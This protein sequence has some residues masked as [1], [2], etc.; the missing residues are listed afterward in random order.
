[1]AVEQRHALVVL[2]VG[3]LPTE[4][5][6]VG[7]ADLPSQQEPAE[8]RPQNHGLSVAAPAARRLARR[9]HGLQIQRRFPPKPKARAHVE[10]RPPAP[11]AVQRG[12][13]GAAELSRNAVRRLHQGRKHV[14]C[15]LQVHHLV[16]LENQGGVGELLDVGT[17]SSRRPG[18]LARGRAALLAR[19]AWLRRAHA[20]QRGG[21]VRHDCH[22]PRLRPGHMPKGARGQQFRCLAGAGQLSK[23]K[24]RRMGPGRRGRLARFFPTVER[25]LPLSVS[26]QD[27]LPQHAVAGCL[28]P[29]VLP[30]RHVLGWPASLLTRARAV[31]GVR[32]RSA[33]VEL[34][35]RRTLRGG[36]LAPARGAASGRRAWRERHASLLS[37]V[38]QRGFAARVHA[39]GRAR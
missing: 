2:V 38:A 15:F 6:A 16:A 24:G 13:G 19:R 21:R 14:E 18:A 3:L 37:P 26:L 31:A 4:A 23:K 8:K 5:A 12:A 28:H 10:I 25:Q 17:R 11:G 32:R 39:R 34:V 29:E 33:L 1:M 36:G 7:P 22:V 30:H 20:A 9:E 27:L 35:H